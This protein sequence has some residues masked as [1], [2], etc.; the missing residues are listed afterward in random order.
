MLLCRMPFSQP[1]WRP[2]KQKCVDCERG[3]WRKRVRVRAEAEAASVKAEHALSISKLKLACAEQVQ[4]IETRARI[5]VDAVR[6]WGPDHAS[7]PPTPPPR[8]VRYAWTDAAVA[9]AIASMLQRHPPVQMLQQH[10]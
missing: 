1:R 2:L 7:R 6:T 3:I 9:S 5:E 10:L 8:C 4:R